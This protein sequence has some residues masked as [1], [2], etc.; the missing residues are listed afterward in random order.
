[1]GLSKTKENVAI[2]FVTGRKS[3][4][5][6]LKTYGYHW[7]GL[8]QEHS[9]NIHLIVAYDLNYKHT[10]VEDYVLLQS[11]L[12]NVFQSVLFLGPKEIHQMI[13]ELCSNGV[14]T[15]DAANLLFEKGYAGKRNAVLYAAIRKNMDALLFLDDDEYPLAV[16]HR[17]QV[18]LWSGQDIFR[19]HIRNLRKYDVTNGYHCGYISPIPHLDFNAEFTADDFRLLIEA[20]SNDILNWANIQEIMQNGGV[21]YADP[22]VFIEHKTIFLEKGGGDGL[23]ISGSNLGISLQNVKRTVPFFNPQ[24]ARGEDTFFSLSLTEQ[25]AARIPVYTFHD[26]FM[27]YPGILNGALPLHLKQVEAFDAGVPERFYHACIG[28]FRYKPLLLYATDSA[29]YQSQA[30]EL[31]R[32]LR[33]TMPKLEAYFH[34]PFNQTIREFVR[35]SNRVQMDYESYQCNLAAWQ[36]LTG[37]IDS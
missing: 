15:S 3:F 37:K 34:L 19:E 23:P 8:I 2:G 18:A 21:T 6:V 5:N 9:M 30:K 10:K 25:K 31:I 24:G 35:F 11:K 17:H 22:N 26:G 7:Q 4:Q 27:Q 13:E 36:E 16:T 20:V 33:Y 1:M 29:V 12:R 32:K 14:L 28:W